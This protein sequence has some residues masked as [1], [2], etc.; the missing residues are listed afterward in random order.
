MKKYIQKYKVIIISLIISLFIEV[1]ICN[2]GFFRTLLIGNINLTKEYEIKD[3]VIKISNINTRVTSIYFEYNNKLKDKVT[4]KLSYKADEDIF[5]KE[6][7]SKIILSNGNHYINFDTHSKCSDIE[8]SYLTEYNLKFDNIILNHPNFNFNLFR[9]ILIFIASVFFLKLKNES[10]YKEQY[11][12]TCNSQN[13]IFII[14]LVTICLFIFMYAI[15]ELNFTKF[16]IYKDDIPKDN[17]LL[18]QTE[19]MVNGQLELLEEPSDALKKME[20]PYDN[21]K[22]QNDNVEYLYDVAFYNN[23]YYNYFGITPI[24]TSILPFRIITGGYTHCYIFNILYIFVAIISLYFLY[25]KIVEK[26]IKKISLFNF[27]LGF[28]GILFASNIFTLLRGLKYDIVMSSG[29]AFLL[30]S[31]NLAL[32]IYNNKKY[33]YIKLIF[34]GITT[35]LIVLSKP[36]LIVYYLIILFLLILTMKEKSLKEKIKDGIFVVIPLGLFAILQMILNYLRFD[37]IFEFGAKYQLTGFNMQYCMLITFGKIYAGIVEYIFKMPIIKPFTFPFVFPNT[38]IALTSINE[39]LYENRLIG[40][41]AIPLLYSYLIKGNIIKDKE[42]NTFLN[43]CVLTSFLSMILNICFGGVCELYSVDFKLI[44]AFG[45]VIILLKWLE[46][47]KDKKVA[48][49]IFLIILLATILIM[50]PINLTT[51]ASFLSDFTNDITVFLKNTFEF[52]A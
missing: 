37:N 23:N 15:S 14:N 3:N 16:F 18:M 19:A 33:R 17:S 46:N 51:E 49:K 13:M 2:F 4:Y 9:V 22:R 38:D 5:V 45:A 39:V 27:Y 36:T 21:T 42:L 31:L 20:N 29:I 50:I 47:S 43:F 41:A 34:L 32:S 40:L 35:A 7:N 6:L 11:D 52:W 30:I 28:Y 24:I 25:K 26:Y 1:F 44:L 10:F 12:S 8:V 48:N